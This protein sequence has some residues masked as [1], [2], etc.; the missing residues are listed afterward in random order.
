MHD[1]EYAQYGTCFGGQVTGNLT[2][3]TG[4]TR[5]LRNR[6]KLEGGVFAGV[7]ETDRCVPDGYVVSIAVQS[8]IAENGQRNIQRTNYLVRGGYGKAL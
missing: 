7:L 5:V 3:G 8:A 4:D 2:Q 1:I 6:T